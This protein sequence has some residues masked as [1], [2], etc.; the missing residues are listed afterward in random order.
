MKMKI[1]YMKQRQN[2][3]EEIKM[4]KK[5]STRRNFFKSGATVI[6]G[7]LAVTR[8]LAQVCGMDTG[9]Q[10][11]GPFFPEE[12]TPEDPIREDLSDGPISLANDSDLTFVRG[13]NGRAKGQVVYIKGKVLSKSCQPIPDATII[14]WQASQ[15][16]RYNHKRDANNE[17]FLDP[18]DGT[19]VERTLD[20]F[21]QC[22]GKAITDENG[23][24][25]FKTIIP[26]FYPADLRNGW[27]RPPHIHFMISATGYPQL[28]T[29]TY[30]KGD[31]IIDND[32]V[33]ELNSKDLLLQSPNITDEQREKL[34]IDF[35]DAPNGI[36]T[37]GLV[38]EL[39]IILTS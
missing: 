22:W 25:Q 21:F 24:Y 34:I 13:R 12:G 16:G 26:G 27:Y 2:N 31:K 37:D 6:V 9:R 28:V 32:W 10:P 20:P 1:F 38:G 17:D 29:Q 3:K 5:L 8:A 33:Q 35:K 11:L 19:V 39:D 15:S 14:I 18:R 36:L 30:F 7:S 4:K 23:E